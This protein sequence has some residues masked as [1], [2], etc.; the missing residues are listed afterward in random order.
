MVNATGLIVPIVGQPGTY[1]CWAGACDMLLQFYGN[2]PNVNGL[3]YYG[4]HSYDTVNG[5]CCPAVTQDLKDMHDLL[6]YNNPTLNVPSAACNSP[7]DDSCFCTNNQGSVLEDDLNNDLTDKKPVLAIIRDNRAGHVVLVVGLDA[8][9]ILTYNDPW[10]VSQ[11]TITYDDFCDNGDIWFWA[12]H[13]VPDSGSPVGQIPVG[14]PCDISICCGPTNFTYQGSNLPYK[15]V[16]TCT[17]QPPSQWNWSLSFNYEGGVYKYTYNGSSSWT[18]SPFSL[19]TTGY[20]WI[21]NDS[22]LV[23]GIVQVSAGG[24]SGWEAVTYTPKTVI[25]SSIIFA[26]QTVSSSHADVNAHYSIQ[27][28]NDQI[29]STGAVNFKA[30]RSI[31]ILP[32]TKILSG[33]KVKITIDPTLQ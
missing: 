16:I 25:P 26:N 18:V 19:P 5:L 4:T 29:T 31:T 28:S 27:L 3:Y 21:Y 24:Y 11:Q 23:T 10:D 7:C 32:E 22:G 20:K 15:A 17:V 12:K 14:P 33:G 6:A 8:N 13:L 1:A 30:G 9:H 2:A